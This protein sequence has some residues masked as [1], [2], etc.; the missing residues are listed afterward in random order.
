MQV[1]AGSELADAANIRAMLSAAFGVLMQQSAG[2]GD[3]TVS[4]I[5]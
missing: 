3:T 5:L 2:I 4:G 1:P